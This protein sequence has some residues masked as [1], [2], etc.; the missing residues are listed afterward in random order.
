[1]KWR[2]SS[3]LI[4]AIAGGGLLLRAELAE[5]LQHLPS[6]SPLQKAFFRAMPL[7][8]GPVEARRP[9][10]ETRPA[11]SALIAA[12]PKDAKLYR[13]RAGE[14]ELALDFTA[15]ETDWKKFASLSNN[16]PAGS[17]ALADF[18]HRRLRPQDEIQA[19]E[20]V[21]KA[22]ASNA[23]KDIP[24][25]QQA[26][27]RALVRI[28]EVADAQGLPASFTTAQL[29]AWIA[30][31]PRER[32]AHQRYFRYLLAGRQ[33]AAAARRIEAYR[34]GFPG[35]E[36]ETLELQADL[37]LARGNS[38]QAIA[39]YDRAFRPL[40]PA[41]MLEKY[42]ALLRQQDKL[43]D[44]LTRAR[45][46]S[47]AH[48]ES[49]D[50]AARVFYYY[51][52][53]NP[54]A[55]R[56]ALME[57]RGRKK[58]WNADEL[59]DLGRLFEGLQ[60]Y[61]EAARQYYALYSLPGAPAEARE[62]ALAALANL[63]FTA[64]DQAIRFGA[65]DLS[66]YKDIAIMDPYP[67]F[68][69]G[70][71]SLV[72]NSTTP[73]AE[74]AAQDRKS[75]AW[76]HRGR[77]S[78]LVALFDKQFP[79][80]AL[81]ADLH[82]RLVETY[83]TY[84]DNQGVIRAGREY[85]DLSRNGPAERRT[86]I[87]LL[88]A[89]AFAR[90]EDT[91]REFALYDEFLKELSARAGGVPIGAKE[92]RSP[93]YAR[94]LDR[95]IAR[96]V[97]LGNVPDALR[98][99]R[100]ELDANPNDSG[101]YERLAAFLEQ[102]KLADEM[103]K[104]YQRAMQQFPD[105]SWHHK[106]ARRYLR[107]DRRQ[108]FERLSREVIGI[109]SGTELESYFTEVLDKNQFD[110]ALYLQLNLYAHQR[111]PNDLAF[112]RNLLA[113]YENPKTRDAAAAESLLRRY[114]YYDDQLRARLFEL[115]AKQGKL[116]TELAA[117]RSAKA[118]SAANPAAARFVAEAEAWR[119]HFESAAAPL[120]TLATEFP[121]DAGLVTRA[122]STYRSLAAYDAHNTEVAVALTVNLN[123]AAPRDTEVL[124]RTGDIYADRELFARARPYWNRIPTIEPGKPSG[125]LE[126]ATI[127]WDYYN[128]SEAL[129][130][131]GE[132]RVKAR[133]PQLY[134][135]ETGAIYEGQRNYAR[136]VREYMQGAL[137]GDPT[138]EGRLLRLARRPA[139]RQIIDQ[140]TAAAAA[141][142]DAGSKALY[143][144]AR[145][146]D[147]QERPQELEAFLTALARR[148][149]NAALLAW[150][151]QEA[152]RQHFT[153]L[154]EIGFER[155]IT[156]TRDPVEKLRQQLA[157]VR[158]YEENHE[159]AA[160]R[161]ALESVYRVD[162]EILGVVRATVDYYW[163]NNLPDSAIE[164][165]LAAA[166]SANA[167]LKKEFQFEAVR[168]ATDAGQY[169][170]ARTLLDLL[171]QADRFNAQ[172]LSALADTYARAGD[173]KGLRAL[174]ESNIAALKQASLS[175]DERM[176]RAAGLRRGLIPALIRLGDYTAA[177]DQYIEIVNR[178]PEDEDLLKESATF[179]LRHGL[180]KRLLDYYTKTASASPRDYR[181]ALVLA[182]LD[183]SL[184]DFPAAIAAYTKALGSRPERTDFYVRR[185]ALEERL[186]RFADTTATYRKL[187]DLSYND[188]Q[189]LERI[190]ELC[191]RQGKT[192]EAVA[193]LRK[194]RLEGRPE[195]AD[196]Q[197]RMAKT[198]AQWEMLEA[199]LPFAER[200]VTMAL[201]AKK[202]PEPI[203]AWLMARL[204]R[205]EAAYQRVPGLLQ[206]LAETARAW[207]SP[208]ERSR[209]A[210]FLEK[211]K[212][213][214]SKDEF[215]KRLLPATLQAGL[216][217]LWA[218][219]EFEAMMADPGAGRSGTGLATFETKR[220]RFAELAQKLEAYW[221]V[222]PNRES[223]D[224]LL[225]LAADAY[226][227]SGDPQRELQ[228]LEILQASDPARQPVPERYL[229][230][231][232]A[233]YPHDL[234]A[235]V[236][237]AAAESS[238]YLAADIALDSGD[239]ALALE[240]IAIRGR[241]I[242]PIWTS[243][244][245][246]LAGLYYNL[247]EERIDR[248]FRS[249]LGTAPIGQRVGKTPDKTRQIVGKGWT[250]Y[251]SRYGEYLAFA[252]N[253]R[254]AD[255]LVA[256]LEAEPAN[257]QAYLGLGDYYAE[258]NEAARAIVEYEHA[259]ELKETLGTVHDRVALVLW[260]QRKGKEA[261]ARWKKALATFDQQLANGAVDDDLQAAAPAVIRHIG[262]HKLFAEL[263]PDIDHLLKDYVA[264]Q[265]TYRFAPLW[266]AALPYAGMDWVLTL[267]GGFDNQTQMLEQ[268][269]T[270]NLIA[271]KNRPEF[272]RRVL[273]LL[274]HTPASGYEATQRP[275][276]IN[277]WLLR[278]AADLVE[279]K[280][281]A[282]AQAALA[283]IAAEGRRLNAREFA[284]LEIRV[285]AQDG[286]LNKLVE[287]WQRFPKK[288]PTLEVLREAAVTVR[289]ES[290]K[291]AANQLLEFG[292]ARELTQGA[293][294]AT[295]FLGLAEVRLDSGDLSGALALLH[296]MN[297]VAG[298]AFEN[299]QSS[300][301][302]LLSFEHPNEALEFLLARQQAEPWNIPV[303]QQIAKLKR[304][305]AGLRALA[306]D[307]VV[308]WRV[309]SDSARALAGLGGGAQGLKGEAAVLTQPKVQAAAA[310]Q[311]L[312]FDS[313][314]AAARDTNEMRERIRLLREAVAVEPDARWARVALVHAAF[315]AGD[316]RL[317]L[318]A[319]SNIL[320]AT[321]D[322][323]AWLGD[324]QVR[325]LTE[326]A[327]AELRL[328]QLVEARQH[329]MA[330]RNA[331]SSAGRR[332]ELWKQIAELD[333][334][335]E[336]AAANQARRPVI[337]GAALEQ[338]HV[339][340]PRVMP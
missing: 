212:P 1:L 67:G 190:A 193:T 286:R 119:S 61:N 4:L 203:Y 107:Y 144:R 214:A 22:P 115:L 126:A 235:I 134:A 14:A 153:K 268:V 304:D 299:L 300:A 27:W 227:A 236:G 329:L 251:G 10:R 184:E 30:R 260:K 24:A 133:Q 162:P 75:A 49:L 287:S 97:A 288:A 176:E 56:R 33:Y 316:Y 25:G 185:A 112:V 140:L 339:V 308:A 191:A 124:A 87:A 159:A 127:Y 172:Y 132:A 6:D 125:Y 37:E 205:Y 40:P 19:L 98:V 149:S 5:W 309:R 195:T 202:A 293:L 291:A 279:K 219:W 182:R 55:A 20:A 229:R 59:Y 314:L 226:A 121:G 340:R 16:G 89:D 48:P 65:G 245:T 50:A 54:A 302:L 247:V 189:W 310:S 131:I 249:T 123:R 142:P 337:T 137:Q 215:E 220:L 92:A 130:L 278:L 143:L 15:A 151:G 255:Y 238:R 17:L 69:N 32:A 148:T 198:L 111:F 51:R 85:L 331:E 270:S 165:L 73:E 28:L 269:W 42:F 210:A 53:S 102:N 262:E 146:L 230:L 197:F 204:G 338:Q 319:V 47:Q 324:E 217:D 90:Q 199:A 88:M 62:R 222:Y 313:R 43:R 187:Y 179:A 294:E 81:R 82:A 12:T 200:G 29:E 86:A 18:Y 167:D 234:L 318:A 330:A 274:R 83:N 72:L 160:A 285:A 240:A 46:D 273:T 228:T 282:Q 166:R 336:R 36:T 213:G 84:V 38:A 110:A 11:L 233:R 216:Y 161:R 80:S 292:Y 298:Q 109:F 254:A 35:D 244:Y 264:K 34:T 296:R 271:E 158:F 183:T 66:L 178:Y 312:Y 136:A 237:G 223:R 128:Y 196:A 266:Q 105:R 272:V 3:L 77:A 211:Q 334:K 207:Y 173:D 243:A 326:V 58:Q 328:N 239:P 280:M 156:L 321:G 71:L 306:S 76:F 192:D 218:Q 261:A 256:P 79:Q 96:L 95:Y 225:V 139:H 52:E 186:M 39:V 281:T 301:D 284:A 2:R 23:E 259:L 311:P 31:Y 277:R 175:P 68:L 208:D 21:A 267:A 94:V 116:E 322:G 135:Y 180:Q 7:P 9:P 283:E 60:E 201:E 99:Y 63:L 117:V 333:A 163:R 26:S 317:V 252:K 295:N 101:M 106:L 157:L 335:L 276:Q 305:T 168:K 327:Q 93:E 8:G 171:L 129:R 209:F 253:A 64:P 263:R 13:L 174:Y 152:E 258:Q 194:A 181:W 320:P 275:Q 113:A 188:P 141:R 108:S 104:V 45:L 250:Y 147:G 100:R 332:E 307:P 150:I 114:W 303:R 289:A 169:A 145:V 248:A 323:S 315:A 120:R 74:F 206:T 70:I 297:L 290:G 325:T 232:A 78:E 41:G 265:G 118:A 224:Y 246:A 164:T 231:V 221:K 138:A 57:L 177:V 242:S 103:E 44:F 91:R 154:Q 122:A 170:R 155:Q 257:P 241:S